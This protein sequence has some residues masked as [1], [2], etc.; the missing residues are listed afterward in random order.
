MADWGLRILIADTVVCK[1]V[2][3]LHSTGH[4]SLLVFVLSLILKP[5]MEYNAIIV[6]DLL[7]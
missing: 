4:A 1:N 3:V 2:V 6:A 7:Y 5:H